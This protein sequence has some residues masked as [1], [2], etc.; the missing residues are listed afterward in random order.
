MVTAAAIAA[1][2]VTNNSQQAHVLEVWCNDR[3]RMVGITIGTTELEDSELEQKIEDVLN[4]V[5]GDSC[6]VCSVTLVPASDE[7]ARWYNHARH[8][9]EQLK[10]IPRREA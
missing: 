8:L 4:T 3:Q 2:L 7:S 1:I 6:F 10:L 5:F 9:A